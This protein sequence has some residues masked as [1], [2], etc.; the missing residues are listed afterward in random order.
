M[1]RGED[2]SDSGAGPRVVRVGTHAIK[3]GSDT[4]LWKR[5]SQHKGRE[6]SGRGNHRGSIFRLIV[7]TALNIEAPSCPTWGQGNTADKTVR[8]AEAV[9]EERVSRIIGQMPF[10]WLAIDD[11]PGPASLRGYIEKN[12][13]ALLSNYAKS[14]IDPPS[15]GWLGH[16]CNREKVRQSGLWNQNHV[17][18]TYDPEFLTTFEGLVE[19]APPA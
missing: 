10:V 12:A 15:P 4:T 3:A 19:R 11:E 18:E 9:L 16:K 8:A 5:L 1:E 17:D 6:R 2:R 14:A 7:G 13:I